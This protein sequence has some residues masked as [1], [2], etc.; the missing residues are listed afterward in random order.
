[1][2][3]AWCRALVLASL[4]AA[5]PVGAQDFTQTSSTVASSP[6]WSGISSAPR[7]GGLLPSSLFD[8]SRFSISNSLMFGV[9]TGSSAYGNGTSGLFTSSLGYR[10]APNMALRLNV[11]AHVNPAFGSGDLS[12]G[13]FLEGASFDWRPSHNSLLRVEYRDVRSP[14]Q[15]S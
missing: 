8:P 6:A 12:K 2:S 10:V 13:V 3:M 1:M 4:L 15:N 7:P 9:S 14:L 11:G 5:A